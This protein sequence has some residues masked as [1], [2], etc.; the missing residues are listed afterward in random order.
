MKVLTCFLFGVTVAASGASAPKV[1][2]TKDV[3]PIF[4]QRC[5]E[6]HR[7]GEIAPMSLLTYE[8]ARP[9]AK[10]IKEK[11][12][13]RIMPP[14]HADP[15]Y[16]KFENDA[17]LSAKEIETIVAWADAGAPKGD[18]KDLPPAPKF[19]EGWTIGQPDVVFAMPE[20]YSV[21]ADGVI[22]YLYFTIPTHFTEDKW[23]QAL[24]IR[25]G[26]RSVVHHVIASTVEPGERDNRQGG[27]GGSGRGQLGGITP[28]KTGV[29]FAPGTGRLIKAGSNIVFQMHYTPTGTAAKDRTRIGLIFAKQPPQK[30]LVSGNAINFRFRIPPGDPNYEVVASTVFKEDTTLTSLTPH[31]HLRGKDFTYTVTYPDGRS[32]ILLKVP[33][34]DFNWQLTY[35]LQEPLILPAGSKLTCVAHFDNSTGNKFNPD[36]SKEVKWGDQTWEEMMIGFFSTVKD[37]PAKTMSASRD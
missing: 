25:P 23:I 1:T 37:V 16:G 15:Q 10:S 12:S 6:C 27:E 35:K 5:V 2:F 20:E 32:E 18:A 33:K 7:P 29:V 22:P 28:N 21:P 31:M 11:V 13:A 26:N 3:A 14:W 24:E 8:S 36:P 9:W 4:Y 19:T 30:M 17:R 34:Y